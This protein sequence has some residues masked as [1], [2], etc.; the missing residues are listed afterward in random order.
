MMYT[1]HH[2]KAAT[3]RFPGG[4]RE[5]YLPGA[6]G[7]KKA[8][9]FVAFGGHARK[10]HKKGALKGTPSGQARGLCRVEKI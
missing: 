9:S 6:H 7:P 8:L 5:I 10:W 4:I 1:I 3:T 2:P